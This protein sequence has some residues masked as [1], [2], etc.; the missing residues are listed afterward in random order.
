MNQR[1]NRS[2]LLYDWNADAGDKGVAFDW[3][4]AR[5][6]VQDETLR[7]G[8]QGASVVDPPVADKRAFL[9]LVAELG[10]QSV[11]L[12]MPAAGARA[13]GDVIALAREI[14]DSRLALAPTCAARTVEDDVRPIIDAAE[15]SGLAI[16][17]ATFIGSSPIR[18]VVESWTL[19]DMVRRTESVVACAVGA[20]LPVMFVT[21]DTTRAAPATLAALY[22]AAIRAGAGRIC[23]C[24]TVGHATPDGVRRLVAYVR[25]IVAGAGGGAI[26]IDW[27]GHRDRGL[28]LA[29]CLAAIEA[30]VDRVHATALGIGERVGNVEMETLLL[31]LTLFGAYRH[32]L[33]ALPAYA[34]LASR[35]Y[36]VGIPVGY[37]LVGADAFSTGTGVHAAAIAK[38]RAGGDD[39]VTEI[40]YS[41]VPASLVGR[42]QTVRLSPYSGHANA[43]W[44][45]AEHGYDAG[46]LALCEALLA[47]AKASD[48]VLTDAEIF[49]VVGQQQRAPGRE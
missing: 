22:G 3:G 28:G 31:N 6:T 5:L 21:E 13:R 37:P 12:G 44:W 18:Q 7:D 45:L 41:G 34:S 43:R 1:I 47:A 26:G 42:T 20:G 19:D 25:E 30:G 36:G 35:I 32:P 16:E 14:A 49:A 2:D 39:W 15:A 17:V 9:H 33:T 46:D 38:A 8:V 23:L 4:N 40:V 11:D 10:V 29:N 24:D 27:H 48:R